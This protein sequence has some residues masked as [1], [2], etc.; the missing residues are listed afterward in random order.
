MEDVLRKKRERL[1]SNKENI[2]ENINEKEN[3]TEIKNESDE[4]HNKL[5]YILKKVI[6]LNNDSTEYIFYFQGYRNKIKVHS[7]CGSIPIYEG[8][9]ISFSQKA[10]I[11]TISEYLNC[12][13]FKKVYNF[14][15]IIK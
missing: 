2:N 3:D 9:K 5:N 10:N 1:V 13:K 6:K 11:N 12:Q 7:I 8:I 15:V 14:W 4:I